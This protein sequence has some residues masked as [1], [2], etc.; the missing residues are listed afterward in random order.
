MK[1]GQGNGERGKYLRNKHTV[2]RRV[3]TGDG[4]KEKGSEVKVMT[5]LMCPFSFATRHLLHASGVFIYLFDMLPSPS[6]I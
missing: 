3:R 2:L 1:D 4:S 6:S 5:D